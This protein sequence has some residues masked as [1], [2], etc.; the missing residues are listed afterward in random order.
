MLL[1]ARALLYDINSVFFLLSVIEGVNHD[2]CTPSVSCDSAYKIS[3]KSIFMNFD[4]VH[5]EKYQH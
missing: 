5:K 1:P 4:Q 3:L 2:A